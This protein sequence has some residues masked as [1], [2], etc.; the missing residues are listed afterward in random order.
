[1]T[2]YVADM[3][4]MPGSLLMVLGEQD[5]L[6]SVSLGMFGLFVAAVLVMV[7]HRIEARSSPPREG[8]FAGCGMGPPI[9]P[10]PVTGEE[11]VI[12]SDR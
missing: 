10:A 9:G 5:S 11:G 6:I 7:R 8:S 12:R 2:D 4:G 3:Y 1:M